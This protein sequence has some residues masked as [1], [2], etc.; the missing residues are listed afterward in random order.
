MSDLVPVTVVITPLTDM[1][2]NFAV[3]ITADGTGEVLS[4]SQVVVAGGG[5][6][7][8]VNYWGANIP[9]VQRHS[10][11]DQRLGLGKP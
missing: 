10:G 5:S 2:L 8:L 4:D 1:P 6:L 11:A 9:T 3:R 7:T